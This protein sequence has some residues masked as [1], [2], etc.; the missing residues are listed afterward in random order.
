MIVPQST[1]VPANGG[2]IVTAAIINYSSDIYLL[3]NTLYKI[4]IE[5]DDIDKNLENNKFET[6]VLHGHEVI[7]KASPP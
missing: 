2:R 4:W 5:V 6:A 7:D 3:P 1:V